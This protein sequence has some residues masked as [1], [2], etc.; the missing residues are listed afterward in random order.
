MTY[1]E[2]PIDWTKEEQIALSIYMFGEKDTFV[3]MVKSRSDMFY[4][5]DYDIIDVSKHWQKTFLFAPF[6]S[7]PLIKP[8][9]TW[10]KKVIEWRLQVGK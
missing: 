2:T 8:A 4:Q 5:T 9:S 1:L 7:L 3:R 10:V 6:K